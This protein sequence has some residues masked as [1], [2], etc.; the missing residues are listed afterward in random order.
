MT[1][2]T[3]APPARTTTHPTTAELK[4][5]F[6]PVFARIAED[7]RDR[8]RDR[9]LGHEAVRLLSESGFTRVRLPVEHGGLGATLPQLIELLVDLGQADSNLPQALHGHFLFTETHQ[10]QSQ[11]ALTDWWLSEVAAGK[12]FGN[13]I[14]E[15][16]ASTGARPAVIE[17]LQDGSYRI[18]G[19]KFYSTGTLLSDHVLVEGV[20]AGSD[21]Q[22]PERVALILGTLDEG[23]ELVDDWNGIG[24]RLTASGTTR[25]HGATAPAERLMTM[26]VPANLLGFSFVWLILAA[27][28]AGIARAAAED[29][30]SFAR[31]R[32]RTYEHA[33]GSSTAQD[34]LMQQ[35]VGQ[36][37]AKASAARAIVVSTA[38]TLAE[39]FESTRGIS[40][41]TDPAF[42]EQYARAYVAVSEA[43]SVVADLSLAAATEVFD[44]GG[45]SV[46]DAAHQLD[47]H[48]R[49]ART[50]ASHSPVA[51]RLRAVGDHRI[52]GTVPPMTIRTSEATAADRKDQS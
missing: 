44:V 40:D 38:A 45:A 14:V 12:V 20:L 28:G 49:N 42:T 51:Y 41:L 27:T 9:T 50:V 25:L 19:D 6:A 1:T 18:T 13:A 10:H 30:A 43:Y 24:Q 3:L 2:L 35:S 37:S 34:P 52:S 31:R 33:S 22:T 7:S 23:V 11:G 26:A 5:R 21:P 32:T 8:E 48:W 16:P 17:P 4:Q 15:K 36:I 46:L 39:A 29:A 47:R